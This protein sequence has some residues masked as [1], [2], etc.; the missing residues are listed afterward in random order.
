MLK[1]T[2]AAASASMVGL[3]GCNSVPFLGG[4]DGSTGSFSAVSSWLPEP[5]EL[6]DNLDHYSFTARSPS[7][8]YNA[9]DEVL[10]K[11]SQGI[12][13]DFGRLSGEDVGY[14]TSVNT[15]VTNNDS[16]S[17]SD[18]GWE[19]YTGSFDT[20]W[21]ADKIEYGTGYSST[22]E[23]TDGRTLFRTEGASGS[24]LNAFVVDENENAVVRISGRDS[25]DILPSAEGIAELL[26]ETNAGEAPTYA[27]KED[28]TEL[29]NGL[30][31]GHAM[32]A[33]T[34]EETSGEGDTGPEDGVLEGQVA[35][36]TSYTID[37]SNT[38]I[39]T[40]IV[41]S[42]ERDVDEG[43]IETY[44]AESGEFNRA[45]ER[46]SYSI[47]GRRVSIEWALTTWAD[48]VLY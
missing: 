38:N 29:T 14:V 19:V 10:W 21:V 20:D 26:F 8:V 35:S 12:S 9:V 37:G 4:D 40:V 30:S 15:N 22:S 16:F 3:A 6:S 45:A 42:E 24:Y 5:Q 47:S 25:G 17:S 7:R 18:I 34:Q 33:G 27:E 39:E 2:G 46:P 32:S 31:M 11:A 23:M 48:E 28:M 1:A 13:T 44:I 41:F 43:D 36:G